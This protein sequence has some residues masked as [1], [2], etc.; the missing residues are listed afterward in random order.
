M[1]NI[2]EIIKQ[3]KEGDTIVWDEPSG[4]VFKIKLEKRYPAGW[5]PEKDAVK[6]SRGEKK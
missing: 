2:I 1:N 6:E 3:L 4:E 5:T